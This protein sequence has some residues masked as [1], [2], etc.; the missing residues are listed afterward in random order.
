M[1]DFNDIKNTVIGTVGTV[2]E[3]A[4]DIAEMAVDKAKGLSRLAKLGLELNSEKTSMEKTYTEIG[5]LYY[6]TRK[7]NPDGFFVQLCDDISLAKEN[8]E[9]INAEIATLKAGSNAENDDSIEVEFEDLTEK[10][11]CTCGC[12]E[13]PAEEPKADESCGCGCGEKPAEEPKTEE[14]CD[15]NCDCDEKPTEEPKAE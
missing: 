6:E 8:I 10:D 4:K 7:G 15:C 12:D 13:K 14:S 9:R 1:A 3:K 2:A 11:P 5:R